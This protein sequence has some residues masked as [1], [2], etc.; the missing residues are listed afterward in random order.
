MSNTIPASAPQR[1]FELNAHW[2]RLA[3]SGPPQCEGFSFESLVSSHP[4]LGLLE[5]AAEDTATDFLVVK[6]GPDHEKRTRRDITGMLVSKVLP[7][8]I[9]PWVLKVYRE[10]MELGQPRYLEMLSC[11]YGQ[12]PLDCCR[13]ILPLFDTNG[14]PTQLLDSWVWHE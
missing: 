9:S 7:P 5:P 6:I 11:V 1:F 4:G 13:L 8:S 14:N 12:E 2:H 3:A 10:T